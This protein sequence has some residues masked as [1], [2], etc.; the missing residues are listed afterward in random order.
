MSSSTGS[1][2]VWMQDFFQAET[3]SLLVRNTPI[4]SASILYPV[5][6]LETL[7]TSRCPL[8]ILDHGP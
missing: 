3:V 8:K 5:M 2:Y 1:T 4:I 6:S 7:E